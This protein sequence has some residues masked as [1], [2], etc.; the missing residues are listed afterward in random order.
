VWAHHHGLWLLLSNYLKRSTLLCQWWSSTQDAFEFLELAWIVLPKIAE[1]QYW[2]KVAGT[3]SAAQSNSWHGVII[4][5][6]YGHGRLTLVVR[7][8]TTP[9]HVPLPW[10]VAEK[11]HSAKSPSL[12]HQLMKFFCVM[13]ET[14]WY[15][16]VTQM[17][18]LSH[19]QVV[20]NEWEDGI[21]PVESLC[22]ILQHK[23]V[24]LW[25]TCRDQELP[26]CRSSFKKRAIEGEFL[27]FHKTSLQNCQLTCLWFQECICQQRPT[28]C[29]LCRVASIKWVR[30][31]FTKLIPAH[32][33]CSK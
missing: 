24:I 11:C 28:A 1:L 6:S 31:S 33:S 27:V 29:R 18:Q 21:V 23:G 25:K 22:Y 5:W 4:G 17:V 9:P 12:W 19:V 14:V 13:M 15:H 32:A 16:S 10:E 20:H 2:K 8:F 3:F 30:V 7:H 26:G